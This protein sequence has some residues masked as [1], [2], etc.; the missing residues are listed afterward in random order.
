MG[1]WE[2][3]GREVEGCAGGVEGL[4][5]TDADPRGRACD[6]DWRKRNR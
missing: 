6:E 5:G 4:G 1:L 2:V 3:T